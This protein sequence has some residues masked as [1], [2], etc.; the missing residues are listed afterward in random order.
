MKIDI[1]ICDETF[2]AWI[3]TL[4]ASVIIT[5]IISCNVYYTNK[6]ELIAEMVKAGN[7]PVRVACALDSDLSQSSPVCVLEG[8]QK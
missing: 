4:I 6:T 3:W 7:D 5:I 1:Q 8:V 2:Y